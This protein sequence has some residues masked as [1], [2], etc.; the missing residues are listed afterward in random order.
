M[1]HN[2]CLMGFTI[3]QPAV[4]Q[5]ATK[6]RCVS[7]DAYSKCKATDLKNLFMCVWVKMKRTAKKQ[8]LGPEARKK[9]EASMTKHEQATNQKAAVAA[10]GGARAQQP[11]REQ[12]CK[13]RNTVKT[14]FLG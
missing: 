7:E 12:D 10:N 13:L 14:C 6:Y 11:I 3:T 5:T 1:S 9:A 4:T 2:K 8:T